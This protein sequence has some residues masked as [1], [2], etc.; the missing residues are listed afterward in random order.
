M[1]DVIGVNKKKNKT[2]VSQERAQLIDIFP[3][4][5]IW[6]GRTICEGIKNRQAINNREFHFS[7]SHRCVGVSEQ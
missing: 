7:Y 4:V 2:R 1:R 5:V 6:E 3:R